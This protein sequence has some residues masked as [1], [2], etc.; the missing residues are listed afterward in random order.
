MKK[1]LLIIRNPD[2]PL[3]DYLDL[4]RENQE[5]F[6]AQNSVFSEKLREGDVKLLTYDARAAKIDAPGKLADYDTML[7]AIFTADLVICI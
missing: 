1:R 3:L 7:D 4:S 5:I 2:S 6:L